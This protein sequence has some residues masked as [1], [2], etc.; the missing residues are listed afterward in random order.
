[1]TVL[2][3][4]NQRNEP[5]ARDTILQALF[6]SPNDQ[7]LEEILS[8]QSCGATLIFKVLTTPFFD[9]NI[10]NDVVQN[11]RNVLLRIK[12]QPQQGYKRL[13]DEVGLSTRSGGPRE[14]HNNRENEHARP[15][16]K[17]GNV[18]GH[19][20]QNFERPV[21][22]GVQPSFDPMSMQRTGSMDSSNFDSFAVNGVN[23]PYTANPAM[24][25]PAMNPQQLQYQQAMLAAARQGQYFQPMGGVN[26]NGYASPATQIDAF[27]NFSSPVT[28]PGLSGSPLMP[29]AGFGQPGF[30]QMV[31]QQ[32][33][34]YPMQYIPQQHM[35]QVGAGRRGRVSDHQG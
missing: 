34:Q 33:Y 18:N 8:D 24:M 6:F 26:M 20:P 22:P 32:M 29:Q 10:R 16:S 15:G 1:L 25:T 23:S 2:K 17:Q 5:E 4:I 13:M 12:A 11:V 19:M 7:V 9:E 35:Q 21:Y 28:T 14:L 27:R 30:N 3:I 31:G